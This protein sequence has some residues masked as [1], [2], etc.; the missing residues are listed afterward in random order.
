MKTKLPRRL[1]CKNI[2]GGTNENCCPPDME[3]FSDRQG[4]A[5][6]NA[7]EAIRLLESE[8]W[9]GHEIECVKIGD[10]I[11]RQAARIAELED[12]NHYQEES[13]R[14]IYLVSTGEDMS[15]GQTGAVA[16]KAI[17]RMQR[18]KARIAE[19]EDK[20][21]WRDCKSEPPENAGDYLVRY[22]TDSM[23][24]DVCK[25]RGGIWFG[26]KPDEWRPIK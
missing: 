16:G 5:D 13:L 1:P 24:C 18:D 4:G 23:W 19:L 2:G 11:R 22:S 15:P 6:V 10:I 21:R 20:L 9:V 14:M 8:R 17:E 12:D 3:S 7:E 25:F 26:R